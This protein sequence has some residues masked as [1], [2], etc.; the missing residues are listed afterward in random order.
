MA[1]HQP[2]GR[3]LP[4]LAAGPAAAAVVRLDRTLEDY[5]RK[6]RRRLFG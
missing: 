5:R 4:A 3:L 6:I 2:L 1:H